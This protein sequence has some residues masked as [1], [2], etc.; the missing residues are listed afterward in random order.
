MTETHIVFDFFVLFL[1]VGLTVA[2]FIDP[3]I[4]RERRKTLLLIIGL[5]AS[6]IIQNHLEYALAS[7]PPRPLLRT[8][9]SIYGYSVRPLILVLIYPIIAPKTRHYPAFILVVVNAAVHLTALF[10]HICFTITEQN[11]YNGGPSSFSA[12]SQAC[13]C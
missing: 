3:Y 2:V 10:S 1:L 11:H 8:L 13:C 9:N 5:C 6:L 12:F 7:G 4:R